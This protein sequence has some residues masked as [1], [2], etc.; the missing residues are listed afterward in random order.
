MDETTPTSNTTAPKDWHTVGRDIVN[1]A[2]TI[3][4]FSIVIGFIVL[5]WGPSEGSGYSAEP[6]WPARIAIAMSSITGIALG[7]IAGGIGT[8]VMMLAPKVPAEDAGPS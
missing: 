4:I 8:I 6:D 1:V 3:A 5:I 2:W 7:L